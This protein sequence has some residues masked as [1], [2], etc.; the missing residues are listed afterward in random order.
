MSLIKKVCE[1]KDFCNVVYVQYCKSDKIPFIIYVDLEPL[2]GKIDGCKN[3][4]EKSS[5][6]KVSEH[7]TSGFSMSTISSFKAIENK[8][9]VCKGKDYMKKFCVYFKEHAMRIINFNPNSPW[10]FLDLCGHGGHKVPPSPPPQ[11]LSMKLSSQ[12]HVSFVS[13]VCLFSC[14]FCVT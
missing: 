4:P 2:M 14:L 8:H 6:T 10:A 9:D 11:D 1:N 7:I 13:I 5:T 3:N 12:K